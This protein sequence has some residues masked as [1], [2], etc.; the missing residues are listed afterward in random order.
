MADA[1]AELERASSDI[2]LNKDARDVLERATA[3]ASER[4]AA[5]AAPTDVLDAITAS[6]GSSAFHAITTLAGDPRAIDAHAAGVDGAAGLP[7]RQLLVNDNREAQV[8]GHYQVDSMLL[9]MALMYSDASVTYAEMQTAGWT[10]YDPR[11][12]LQVCDIPRYS[13]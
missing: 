10:L 3:L 5:Q 6:S 13:V 9:L 8:L 11:W 12:T 1:T 2:P 7:L 4:G